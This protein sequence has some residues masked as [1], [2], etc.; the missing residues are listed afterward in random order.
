VGSQVC[1]YLSSVASL[2]AMQHE[3]VIWDSRNTVK[4]INCQ[5]LNCGE[6][7]ANGCYAHH[8]TNKQTNTNTHT[9]THKTKLCGN[10]VSRVMWPSTSALQHFNLSLAFIFRPVPHVNIT[11]PLLGEHIAANC[12]LEVLY[13]PG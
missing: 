7:Q 5:T 1:G 13:G 10:S 12:K 4:W 6:R 11:V 9:Y 3:A 8:T 2:R